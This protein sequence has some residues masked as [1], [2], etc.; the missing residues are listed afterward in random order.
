MRVGSCGYVPS[1]QVPKATAS[2]GLGAA[3][4]YLLQEELS[5][6]DRGLRLMREA[7]GV[8]RW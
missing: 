7:G 2:R 1:C 4:A 5:I 3:N 6:L 8:D